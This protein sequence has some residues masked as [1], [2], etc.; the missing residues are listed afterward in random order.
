MSAPHTLLAA[1]YYGPAI[2]ALFFVL[3]ISRVPEPARRNFNAILVAG[4]CG[5]YLSGGFGIWELAYPRLGYPRR[6]CG[7]PI[8]PVHWNGMVDA[9][10]LGSGT[11]FMG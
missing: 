8:V 6:L 2:G 11:P 1:D 5:A 7:T 10:C 9:R 3:I 4:A